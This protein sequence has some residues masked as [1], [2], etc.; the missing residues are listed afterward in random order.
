M[1]LVP[2]PDLGW[3]AIMMIIGW[4]ALIISFPAIVLI[5][6][7]VFWY[8]L[9][10][11]RSFWHSAAL[12]LLVNLVSGALGYLGWMNGMLWVPPPVEK[13][14]GEYTYAQNPPPGAWPIFFSFL[15]L[16]FWGL[17]ILI[18]GAIMT[19]AKRF[20][21]SLSV[22]RIW[23]A[24]LLANTCSYLALFVVVTLWVMG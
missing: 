24:A 19:L 3:G 13:Y 20:W 10:P 12:A 5:E 14:F 21:P 2:S 6:A 15:L 23:S 11:G 18:E 17:S 4:Y 16:N 8:T 22:P 1:N 7:V 9:R